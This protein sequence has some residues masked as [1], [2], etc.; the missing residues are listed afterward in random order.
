MT[1]TVDPEMARKLQERLETELIPRL[2]NQKIRTR[3]AVAVAIIALVDRQIGRGEGKLDQEWER[4]RDMTRDQ[5]KA[6]NLVETLKGAI[7]QYDDELRAKATEA[8]ADETAMRQA[9]TGVIRGAI[10][11]KLKALQELDREEEE[12]EANA[13]AGGAQ[14]DAEELPG[15]DEK[16]ED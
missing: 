16:K 5:P 6:L 10:M 9:A 2:Q 14:A 1:K 7:D 13:K 8:E 12:R 15:L 11:A 3:T 4:L